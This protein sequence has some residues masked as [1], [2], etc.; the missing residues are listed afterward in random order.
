VRRFEPLLL[1]PGSPSSD[2]GGQG[3][4]SGE[5]EGAA[6]KVREAEAVDD[7]DGW[8]EQLNPRSLIDMQ[9]ALVE[10]I[11]ST[12]A[13]SDGNASNQAVQFMRQ[14][15]FVLDRPV[16]DGEETGVRANSQTVEG[17]SAYA[18]VVFNEVVPLKGAQVGV[19]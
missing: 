17:D 6:D 9:A 19:R 2:G 16:L 5:V 4:A 13:I 11:A 3:A 14:G 1:A 12:A 18:E 7:G 8:M 10:R 15:Y